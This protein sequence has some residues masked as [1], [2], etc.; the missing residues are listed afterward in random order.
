MMIT[1]PDLAALELKAWRSTHEDGFLDMVLG[2]ML[3]VG[4]LRDITG[5]PAVTLLMLVLP[6]LF[7][8][9][10]HFV[11]VP[12]IGLVHFSPRRQARRRRLMLVIAGTLVTTTA[13]YVLLASGTLTG[14]QAGAGTLDFVMAG[15]LFA[16]FAAI[17]HLLDLPRLYLAAAVFAGT[18]LVRS[19]TDSPLVH[20]VAGLV[21]F[22]PGLVLCLRFLWRY[23]RPRE[24]AAA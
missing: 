8:L 18:A 2:G 15:M 19:Y 1:P 13:L 11:T 22:L 9:G 5:Q 17:A 6:A 4:C 16:V 14:A 23:P 10:K 3:L 24:G 7:I 20:L 12:R 21:I